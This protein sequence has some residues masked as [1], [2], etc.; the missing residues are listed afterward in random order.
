MA[1]NLLAVDELSR[2]YFLVPL[3]PARTFYDGLPAVV[4][5]LLMYITVDEFALV[6]FGYVGEVE[7]ITRCLVTEPVKIY[8]K[9]NP[10]L[11][12]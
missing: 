7:T 1:V 11:W 8:W 12:R 6:Q 10:L 4:S 5:A 9:P 3:A 2:T